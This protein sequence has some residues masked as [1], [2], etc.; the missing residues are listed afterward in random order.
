MRRM[1]KVTAREK[2][3]AKFLKP[4]T[5]AEEFLATKLAT[6]VTILQCGADEVSDLLKDI[7]TL[8]KPKATTELIAT[9]R[10][11]EDEGHDDHQVEERG[12]VV[13][14]LQVAMIF[15]RH[16]GH[17]WRVERRP[18]VVAQRL[19]GQFGFRNGVSD[20]VL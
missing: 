16:P 13:V 11:E 15:V 17:R 19:T 3:V 5:D 20:D 2:I 4:I 9:D 1:G 12:A 6:H 8:T 18:T 7:T 14:R 10:A